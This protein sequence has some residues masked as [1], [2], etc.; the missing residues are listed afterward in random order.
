[1]IRP[2]GKPLFSNL[3]P[4]LWS[5]PKSLVNLHLGDIMTIQSVELFLYNLLTSWHDRSSEPLEDNHGQVER[6]SSEKYV[7]SSQV[8][9]Q[10][11]NLTGLRKSQ[12]VVLGNKA[13]KLKIYRVHLETITKSS[14]KFVLTKSDLLQKRLK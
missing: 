6:Y 5:K 11:K 8:A 4:T 7:F 10:F 13:E 1:M 3:P 9:Q 14:F 12:S 2:K